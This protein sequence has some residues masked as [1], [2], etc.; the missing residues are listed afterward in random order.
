MSLLLPVSTA[1]LQSLITG[2]SPIKIF[3]CDKH[4]WLDSGNEELKTRKPLPE[5]KNLVC[6]MRARYHPVALKGLEASDDDA[7]LFNTS[8]WKVAPM[9]Y[10]GHCRY[11]SLWLGC[12]LLYIN[13]VPPKITYKSRCKKA[14][15]AVLDT[16][17]FTGS[18]SQHWSRWWGF[19][20]GALRCFD[21]IYGQASILSSYLPS[22]Y[23]QKSPSAYW[24]CP[25]SA[26]SLTSAGVA[27][28]ED[29]LSWAAQAS[30]PY[31]S[32]S[33]SCW[34]DLCAVLGCEGNGAVKIPALI[35]PS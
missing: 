28:L 22:V 8:V 12:R 5:D 17:T 2:R 14:T 23:L 7:R 4:L 1:I 19:P 13:S 3:D 16:V 31:L 20:K 21:S 15:Q 9:V 18:S 10:V 32:E 11:D 29:K 33:A 35:T 26:P 24:C 27:S 6:K 25:L 34:E 30:S